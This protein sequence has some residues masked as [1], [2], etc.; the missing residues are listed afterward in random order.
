VTI[1]QKP[2]LTIKRSSSTTGAAAKNDHVNPSIKERLRTFLII[3]SV[4]LMYAALIVT[5][6]AESYAAEVTKL[7]QV[8]ASLSD[9]LKSRLMSERAKLAERLTELNLKFREFDKVCADV[10]EDSAEDAYCQAT[11]GRLTGKLS[12]HDSD[13]KKFNRR[14]AVEERVTVLIG[15]AFRMGSRIRAYADKSLNSAKD[16][17]RV[18]IGAWHAER[19]SYQ[20]ARHLARFPDISQ[21]DEVLNEIED[22]LLSLEREQRALLKKAITRLVISGDFDS[23]FFS[24][25]PDKFSISLL[26]AHMNIKSQNYDDAL[27]N[28]DS[29]KK[30][31]IESQALADTE[32]YVRQM[33]VSAM[34]KRTPTDPALITHQKNLAGAYAGWTLGM[35]LMDSNMDATAIQVLTKSA[36]TL[37]REGKTG[38]STTVFS[39]M[40]KI[41]EKVEKNQDWLPSPGI[42]DT[43]SEAD[44]L[45][46]SL[47][48]GSGDWKRSLLFLELAHKA[49]PDNERINEAI[50]HT[51]A[52][53][54]SLR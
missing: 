10:E 16:I 19:G 3:I 30:M 26:Q 17:S 35:L 47:E 34:E 29:A 32:T 37:A 33:K 18:L 54:A 24:K 12:A 49:S 5:T 51:Q 6:P 14:I 9:P 8:P 53:I 1:Q 43:A 21:K 48:Y 41:P 44:I 11:A 23:R 45:F 50:A 22:I 52:L 42:Y 36:Q 40:N 25:Y 13:V 20:K 15:N 39:L 31:N 7:S 28:I 27:R 4:S 38:D 46:D 2:E